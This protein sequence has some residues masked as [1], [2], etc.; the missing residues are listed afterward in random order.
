MSRFTLL[1]SYTH[2]VLIPIHMA[3]ELH[4]ETNTFATYPNC[5]G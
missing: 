2:F 4:F 5:Q 1:V 3:L